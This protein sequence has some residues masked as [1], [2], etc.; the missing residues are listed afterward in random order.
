MPLLSPI[1]EI[2]SGNTI[3]LNAGDPAL[4]GYFGGGGATNSAQNVNSTTAL[5]ISTVYACVNRR[6]KTLAT[7]P[8]QIKKLTEDGGSEVAYNHRLYNQLMKNPNT[9]QTRYD[10]LLMCHG[11]VLLRGNSYNYIV[12]HPGRQT[13]ELIPMDPDRV[14]PF[15]IDT[16]GATYHLNDNSP[17]PPPGSKLYYQYFP[18]NGEVV[19]LFPH[20][21]LHIKGFSTNG[22]VG[23]NVIQIMRESVGLAM[24]EEEQGARLF[25][26]GAQVGKVFSHPKALGDVAYDRLKKEINN[27]TAGVG[28]SHKSLLLEDG[29]TITPTTLTMQDAEFLDSRK[30]QVE[31]LCSYLDV[32]LILIHRSGDKNQ[33]F[34]SSEVIKSIFVDFTVNSDCTNW[35]QNLDK[36]LLYDSEKSRYFI[37]FDL[38][39]LMRGDTTART[40]YIKGR[41]ETGSW[42]PDDI[43]RYEGEQATGTEEG[44]AYYAGPGTMPLKLAGQQQPSQSVEPKPKEEPKGDDD[45]E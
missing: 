25:S 23:K 29:M 3:G 19:V 13:N 40:K 5:K 38:K 10:W 44:R 36:T 20:E 4:S 35:E 41:F 12:Y 16:N 6:A 34:A 9:W 27:N 18:I 21:V 1:R 39:A 22:I 14:W 8:L 2:R 37:E 31:D 33:T 7:L 43:R 42:S 28:N 11:H 45:D 30:F 15:V 24:A 17:A 26:N 32:P